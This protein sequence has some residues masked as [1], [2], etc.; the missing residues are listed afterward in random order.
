METHTH[1]A[2]RWIPILHKSTRSYIQ[3][4]R[5]RN[6]TWSR[7][8]DEVAGQNVAHYRWRPVRLSQQTATSGH[9]LPI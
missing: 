9:Q 2:S 1:V 6:G 5:S 4:R 7:V 8:E 3:Y